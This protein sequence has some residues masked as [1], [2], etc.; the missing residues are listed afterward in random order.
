MAPLIVTEEGRNP[1]LVMGDP[2]HNAV[3]E[4]ATK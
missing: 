4:A 2:A 3:A 1:G